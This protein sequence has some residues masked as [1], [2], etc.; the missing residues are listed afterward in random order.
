M[1]PERLV[2]LVL[3]SHIPQLSGDE[4]EAGLCPV[5]GPDIPTHTPQA[6][7]DGTGGVCHER[8]GANNSNSHPPA[9][10]GWYG[11]Y[12]VTDS[13]VALI[14]THIPQPSGDGTAVNLTDSCTRGYRA[15]FAD[16]CCTTRILRLIYSEY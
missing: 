2:V 10:G 14:P 8:M 16:P 1:P 12:L 4:S 3:P 6:S 11:V 9:P 15:I 5:Y 7:G 13:A